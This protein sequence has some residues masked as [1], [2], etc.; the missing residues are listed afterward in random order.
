MLVAIQLFPDQASTL[1]PKVDGV[2]YAL[3]AFSGFFIVLIATL[4]ITFAIKYRRRSADEI[5]PGVRSPIML[6]VT[7]VTIPLILAL[8]IFYWGAQVYFE[9]STPPADALEV[10]V[11][12]KQWMWHVQ[13]P[14]GQREINE[15][16]V[17]QGKPIKLTMISQD[18]IHNFAVPEFRVRQDVFPVRYSTMWFTPTKK[19][20]FRF[21]C[22]EYCGTNHSHMVGWINVMEPAQFK[23]WLAEESDNSLSTEGGKRFL[24]LQCITCHN[25]EG[26]APL[27]EEIWHKN[28]PLRDGGTAY[29][30]EQYLRESILNPDAKIVAGFENIMPSFK[31]QLTETE[32]LE[33]IVYIRSLK[34]GETPLRNEET[35]PPTVPPAR[36]KRTQP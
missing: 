19:G 7:W 26:A 5:P 8:G 36:E 11:V 30:D 6:E 2:Y 4:V 32:L 16:H 23:T 29:V 3:L 27:L 28:I 17:P 31:G 12:G 24:E 14:G 22:A 25:R 35:E 1:A 20:R 15:L 21:F 34:A 33:L 13:H 9:G 18:V 10:Y